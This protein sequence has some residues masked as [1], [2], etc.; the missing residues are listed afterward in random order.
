MGLGLGIITD[1]FW[2]ISGHCR[3]QPEMGF[4]AL[5]ECPAIA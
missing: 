1:G 2:A 3:S 5:C 4:G